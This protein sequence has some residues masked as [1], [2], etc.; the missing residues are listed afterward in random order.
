LVIVAIRSVGKEV[1][2]FACVD[3][4]EDIFRLPEV[5]AFHH[6][7]IVGNADSRQDAENDD[8]DEQLR[9]RKAASPPVGPA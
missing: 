2:S 8:H 6:P 5:I 9:Q 1:G 3:G 7:S 4:E